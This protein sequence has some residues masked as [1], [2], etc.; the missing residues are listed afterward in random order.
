MSGRWPEYGTTEAAWKGV[1]VEADRLC[2]LHLKVKDNLVNESI[3]KVKTWQKDTY[4]KSMIQ[5]KERKEME[6]A[7]KKA[8]KPWAKL[9][10]KVNKAK[11]DYHTACKQEK[12]ASNQE[13]NATG[14]SSFSMDQVQARELYI[15]IYKAT[16]SLCV[17]GC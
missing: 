10:A 14:D 4:H 9:L 7:F 5:I 6:D 8:Q 15:Y 17:A 1:L 3:H 2:E 12:S 13:R 11:S 16:A